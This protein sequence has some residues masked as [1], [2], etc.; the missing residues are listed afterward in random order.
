[1]GTEDADGCDAEVV[2]RVGGSYRDFA[3]IR[4][5]Y[6]VKHQRRVSS[7]AKRRCMRATL[8]NDRSKSGVQ[9]QSHAGARLP[10]GVAGRPQRAEAPPRAFSD[11]PIEECFEA[12]R[13]TSSLSS[14]P[15]TIW[16]P[17][18]RSNSGVRNERQQVSHAPCADNVGL[19]S[20]RARAERARRLGVHENTTAYPRTPRGGAARSPHRGFGASSSTLRFGVAYS[21]RTAGEPRAVRPEPL[22]QSTD[23]RAGRRAGEPRGREMTEIAP[24]KRAM[25]WRQA[26]QEWP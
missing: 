3:A 1:M 5:E 25:R 10:R 23:R 13:N 2:E 14:S 22:W 15:A 11:E 12:A 21:E 17:P 8:P 16:R 20:A 9:R 4:D 18:A 24:P 26:G 19:R 6:A 7:P